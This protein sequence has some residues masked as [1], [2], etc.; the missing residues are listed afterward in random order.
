MIF[1]LNLGGDSGLLL[2]PADDLALRYSRDA[3]PALAQRALVGEVVCSVVGRVMGLKGGGLIGA[4]GGAKGDQSVFAGDG[5]LI[6]EPVKVICV[7]GVLM[8]EDDG[9]AHGAWYGGL[10]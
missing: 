1:P 9:L 8:E 4:V 10:G 5:G 2:V 7:C 6:D 3:A